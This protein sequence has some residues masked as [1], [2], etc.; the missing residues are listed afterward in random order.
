MKTIATVALLLG[1]SILQPTSASADRTEC[2]ES[3]TTLDHEIPPWC[4]IGDQYDAADVY[5]T[6]RCFDPN[7]PSDSCTDT[8]I[9]SYMHIVGADCGDGG[10]F[11][12]LDIITSNGCQ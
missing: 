3:W 5:V 9:E 6:R 7:N 12:Q 2:G 10:F 8:W 11:Q 1:V 4:P